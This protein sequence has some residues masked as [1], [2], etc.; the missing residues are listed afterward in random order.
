[1]VSIGD[2]SVASPISNIALKNNVKSQ[3]LLISILKISN[4]LEKKKLIEQAVPKIIPYLV[5]WKL[6]YRQKHS[7]V[8]TAA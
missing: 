6:H 7:Y 2:P 4:A 5:G 3:F 8:L 1:M